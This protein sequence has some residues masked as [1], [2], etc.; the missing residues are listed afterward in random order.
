MGGPQRANNPA[1]A[2]DDAGGAADPI[3]I[4]PA[5]RRVQNCRRNRG[6]FQKPVLASF[7][8]TILTLLQRASFNRVRTNSGRYLVGTEPCE[9]TASW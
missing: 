2:E 1:L 5:E 7:Q 4:V 9:I 8:A 6:D 3:K